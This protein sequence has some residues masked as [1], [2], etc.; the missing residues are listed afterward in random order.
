[1]YVLGDSPAVIK[2]LARYPSLRGHVAYQR[3]EDVVGVTFRPAQCDGDGCVDAGRESTTR[4][5]NTTHHEGDSQQKDSLDSSDSDGGNRA[6]MRA[7][8]D[9]YVA[10]LADADVQLPGSSFMNAGA[11]RLS[12]T[13]DRRNSLGFGGEVVMDQA[14]TPIGETEERSAGFQK[15]YENYVLLSASHCEFDDE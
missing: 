5:S 8:V 9:M 11:N 13:N 2:A 7:V 15:N 10:S 3:D 12:V 1:M 6:W 4:H 14:V